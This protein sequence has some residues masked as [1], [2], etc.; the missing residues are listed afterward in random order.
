MTDLEINKAIATHIFGWEEYDM[1]IHNNEPGWTDLKDWS[2]RKLY[3]AMKNENK[4]N[5]VPDYCNDLNAMHEAK[6]TLRDDA[7]IE[8]IDNLCEIVKRDK[9][10]NAGPYSIMTLAFFATARQQAEAF[11]KTI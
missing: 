7:R 8:F 3:G 9:N 11:L 5:K 2:D 10:I 6:N 1:L 4:W